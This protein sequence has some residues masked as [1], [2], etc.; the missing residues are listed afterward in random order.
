MI[1]EG[2]FVRP[3][4]LERSKRFN[5]LGTNRLASDPL[6]VLF[7]VHSAAL[8]YAEADVN[9]VGIV[10]RVAGAAGVARARE[11]AMDEGV[12]SVGGMPIGSH[13]VTI[14]FAIF[15]GCLTIV[16][17]KPEEEIDKY[18]VGFAE[19]TLEDGRANCRR[20]SVK[21]N[22]AEGRIHRDDVGPYFLVTSMCRP[23]C[24]AL[25]FVGALQEV[26]HIGD[27]G[28]ERSKSVGIRFGC[29]EC[30]YIPGGRAKE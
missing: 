5:Y 6:L 4:L 3:E 25:V 11:E 1:D 28:R 19:T 16:F 13:T 10:H 30:V 18:D 24:G 15:G 9:D 2:D 8:D 21:E 7:G 20:H 22:I 12:E 17:D 26:R 14:P 23:N 29:Q 27:D